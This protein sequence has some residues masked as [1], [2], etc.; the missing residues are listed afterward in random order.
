MP[1]KDK[2]DMIINGRP[3]VTDR[4]VE[5][6][7]PATGSVFATVARADRATVD[8]AVAAARR[9][10]PA[11]AAVPYSERVAIMRKIGD[12]LAGHADE[13]GR[14]VT[15]EQG[16]PVAESVGEVVMGSM[17]ARYLADNV[18][19]EPVTYPSGTGHRIVEHRKPLGVVAAITPWNHPLTLLW[20]KLL[21]ALIAGNTVIV[22][23]AATTP[24]SS[25]RI[26]EL[27]N[28]LLPAGV[29][30]VIV[31]DNDL[32]GALTSHPGVD[33]IAFTGSTATGSKVIASAAATI[34]R[35][36]LELGGN[37]PAIV[38]DD[39]DVAD[40]A[41]RVYR[42]ATLNAGQICLAAKRLFVPSRIY[43]EFC[44]ELVRHANA[45]VI[46]N[47]LD[48]ATTMG[49]IQNA[50]QYAKTQG[51]LEDAHQSGTVIAGG[52][53]IDGPGYFVQPTIV[54]DIPDDAR[55]VREEQFCPVVPVLA[56]DNIDDAVTRANAT[57]YG[58]GGTVWGRDLDRAFDVAGR[59]EA[60][61]VWVN[62]HMAFDYRVP[63]R[64]AKHSGL[65][66]ELGQE[67]WDAFT[68]A[69]AV[70]QAPW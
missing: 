35:I 68:Q 23:P 2:Y 39:V 44:G 51:Y 57:E 29:L 63:A 13:V 27:L 67:G 26:T 40:A 31:D 50:M 11:W 36:T 3:V 30:N 55:L 14:L 64:G 48:P 37:D 10:F 4:V 61:T 42:A 46:G 69:Y 52:A 24:L 34:K 66:G 7:N 19:F 15:T 53:L 17:L 47:G 49:P 9:A 6:I 56:Y 65:G 21:P 22:K 70:N 5:V 1:D 32:G 45:E 38:L 18:S 59:I 41:R 58:L 43:D 16:K 28:D 25:V 12:V 60:G 33:H 8:E 20:V 54:R 62:Q